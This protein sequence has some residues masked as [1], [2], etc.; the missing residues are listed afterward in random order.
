MKLMT[1]AALT[2]CLSP[3]VAFAATDAKASA[4]HQVAPA[5]MTAVQKHMQIAVGPNRNTSASTKN[6]G[7]ESAR[8]KKTLF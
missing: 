5:Q 8:G 7:R 6:T 3:G 2:L 4:L 1:I